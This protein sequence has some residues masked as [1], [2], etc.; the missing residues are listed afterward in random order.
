VGTITYSRANKTRQAIQQADIHHLVLE[1]DAP[2]MPLTGYQGQRNEPAQCYK[3]LKELSA[4]REEPIEQLAEVI[5][6]NTCR[7][8]GEVYSVVSESGERRYRQRLN[9]IAMK[10]P[11][12]IANPN[13]N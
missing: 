6:N 13:K 7:L 1:T 9:V 4:L 11:A 12:S 8:F 3:V 5:W 2:D 10:I